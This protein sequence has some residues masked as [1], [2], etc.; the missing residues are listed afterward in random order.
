M[1]DDPEILCG[2]DPGIGAD[3]TALAVCKVE[4]N[5]FKLIEFSLVS[6][7]VTPHP[8][9]SIQCTT[10][11]GI[12]EEVLF[13]VPRECPTCEGTGW[14]GGK[15]RVAT[16]NVKVQLKKPA[17]HITLKFDVDQERKE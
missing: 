2:V 8:V 12:G 1:S 15:A 14:L 3:C 7:V 11:H 9:G 13:Q 10:C 6:D 4:N 5:T 17:D 16:A